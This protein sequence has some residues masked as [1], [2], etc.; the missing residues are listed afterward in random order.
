MLYL[1]CDGARIIRS[2]RAAFLVTDLI[3]YETEGHLLLEWLLAFD[4]MTLKQQGFDPTVRRLSDTPD[5]REA[6]IAKLTRAIL[7]R[8]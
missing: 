3:S 2:E 6:T 8:C 4:E 7:A 5:H 1:G